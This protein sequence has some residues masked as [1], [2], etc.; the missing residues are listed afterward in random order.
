[1]TNTNNRHTDTTDETTL[2]GEITCIKVTKETRQKL[3]K[4]GNKG[5]TYDTVISDL[6]EKSCNRSKEEKNAS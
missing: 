3:A 4:I 1:M 6:L 2:G 5:D